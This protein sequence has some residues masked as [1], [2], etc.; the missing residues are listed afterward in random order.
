MFR[1]ITLFDDNLLDLHK[2][3]LTGE[4]SAWTKLVYGH[5]CVASRRKCLSETGK[6][7]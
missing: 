4:R 2:E 7:N 5:V 6:W 1:C 3:N